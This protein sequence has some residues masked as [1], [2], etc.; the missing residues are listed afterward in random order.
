[1]PV[2]KATDSLDIKY[3]PKSLE[4]LVGQD[5][6]VCTLKGMFESGS[7]SCRTIML[8]GPAGSGK[9]STARMIARYLNCTGETLRC[10]ECFTC[11]VN[12]IEEE[13]PDVHELNMAS[14]TGVDNIRELV[15]QAQYLPQTNFRI[16]I[17]DEAQQITTA[18]KECLLKPLEEPPDHVVWILCTTEPEKFKDT[19]RGRCLKLQMKAIQPIDLAKLLYKVSKLEGSPLAEDKKSIME[20]AKLVRG[21]PRD[22]LKA[23][24]KV[25]LYVKGKGKVDLSVLPQIVKEVVDLPPDVAISKYLLSIY[26]G[27][28]AT[29]LTVTSSIA[30]AEYF[31]RNAIE[32]QK[33][34]LRASAKPELVESYPA[35]SKLITEMQRLNIKLPSLAHAEI[36]ENMGETYTR[37]KGYTMDASVLLETLTCKLI[38]KCNS[39]LE[40]VSK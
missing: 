27:K 14:M 6:V 38:I 1:M 15:G 9:S 29:A 40:K 28:F 2:L 17:L 33:N 16:Y 36:L 5:E 32:F 11:K 30:N 19:V 22:G 20:I 4:D 34:M 7:I 25:M 21:Q 26:S 39:F 31:L 10:G 23:L 35:Y 18:G 24:E 37:M 3:R 8:Y 13:H 12:K